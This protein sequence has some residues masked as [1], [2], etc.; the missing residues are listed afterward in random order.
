MKWSQMTTSVLDSTR[1]VG[2]IK[3]APQCNESCEMI[4]T[5]KAQPT[6]VE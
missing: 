3:V 2:N 6:I 1:E 4:F 5:P